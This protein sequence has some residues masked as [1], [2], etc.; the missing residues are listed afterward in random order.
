MHPGNKP[1]AT[2]PMAPP[3]IAPRNRLGPKIPSQ[4][5][6]LQLAEIRPL[7]WISHKRRNNRNE[8]A[9]EKVNN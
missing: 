5:V 6:L 9:D 8:L 3:S 7:A 1:W 2:A 4:R